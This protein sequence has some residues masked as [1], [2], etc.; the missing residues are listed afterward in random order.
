MK[1]NQFSYL[2]FQPMPTVVDLNV[3]LYY[4]LENSDDLEE[5]EFCTS[6]DVQNL[7]SVFLN[8]VHL[9]LF[10]QDAESFDALLQFV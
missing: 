7:P 6:V 5:F 9:K 1:E 4:D 3:Q 10:L 8:L 2:L